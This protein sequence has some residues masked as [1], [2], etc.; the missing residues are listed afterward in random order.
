MAVSQVC[1]IRNTV[2]PAVNAICGIAWEE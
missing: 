1:R 2:T